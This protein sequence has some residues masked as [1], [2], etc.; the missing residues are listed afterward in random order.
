MIFFLIIIFHF[1]FFI[2]PFFH[3]SFFFLFFIHFQG[4]WPPGVDGSEYSIN[5][6]GRSHSWNEV[7]VLATADDYGRVR[8]FN[9]PC[10]SPGAPDKCYKGHSNKLTNI[11]FSNDDSYCVTTGGCDKCVFVWGTDII[12]EKRERE[13]LL[14]NCTAPVLTP[15]LKRSN[16]DIDTTI[17]DTES[18]VP[19]KQVL[20]G[21]GDES[22]AIKPWAGAIRLPT[23]YVEPSDLGEAPESSLELKFVYGYRGW[24]CRNNISYADSSQEIVYHVAG[25]GIVFNSEK[26]SQVLNTEH[27]DDILCLAMH[28][29]G[30]TVATGESGPFPKIGTCTVLTIFSCFY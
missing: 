30:H 26:Q 13:A 3:S 21:G 7:P 15:V 8:I 12:E 2:F 28:P 29:E 16:G 11:K 22:M 4:I 10:V 6:V 27:D 14:G 5:T 18:Y 1:A 24:D 17:V 23:G 25:V 19:F 9:Y 20:T